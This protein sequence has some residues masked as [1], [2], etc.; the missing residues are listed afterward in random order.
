M[1]TGFK[2]SGFTLIELLVVIAIAIGLSLLTLGF[3]FQKKTASEQRTA[4][5]ED[6]E[7]LFSSTKIQSL[8]G[9]GVL[10]GGQIVVPDEVRVRVR[11]GSVAVVYYSGGT[12]MGTGQTLA[13]PFRNNPEFEIGRLRL[14]NRDD[15]VTELPAAEF[16]VV[17]SRD[18]ISFTGASV[19][20]ASAVSAEM[21]I[22]Y[23]NAYQAVTVDKRANRVQIEDACTSGGCC[24]ERPNYLLDS[25]AWNLPTMAIGSSTDAITGTADI[26]NGVRIATRTFT[27]MPD[28]SFSG[29]VVAEQ[30]A[31]CDAGYIWQSATSSCAP[32]S[33][34]AADGL[35]LDGYSWNV[36]ELQLGSTGMNSTGV[37]SVSHG[38]RSATRTFTC[39]NDG[40]LTGNPLTEGAVTCDAGYTW[41]ATTASCDA[42]KCAAGS[43]Q[44]SGYTWTVPE[45]I[46]GNI[47]A[48]IE[49]A[50]TTITHGTRS[51]TRAFTCI[52][53]TRTPGAV[54]LNP[55]LCES[56]YF[57]STSL[58]ACRSNACEAD[59]T[60]VANG[61]T[62]NA[63]YQDASTVSQTL[64]GT[65]T[66]AGGTRS[67][68]AK[69]SC[70]AT[71]N[72]SLTDFSE[73]AGVCSLG[74]VWSTSSSACVAS[75]C[76]SKP[77]SQSDYVFAFPTTGSGSSAG[78]LTGTK[79]IANGV[80][81]ATASFSCMN[82]TITSGA[83]TVNPTAVCNAGYTWNSV[84]GLCEGA[85]CAANPSYSADGYVWN[86]PL[87]PSG[88]TSAMV[89]GT[90]SVTHGTVYA[91][92]TFSCDAGTFSPNALS[93]NPNGTCDAGY[94]WNLSLRQC[95]GIPCQANSA[96]TASGY[97]FSTPYQAS[98]Y[99]SPVISGRKAVSHGT[100]I[101]RA[102]FSCEQGVR[103]TA[104]WMVDPGVCETGYYWD[105]V[106]V[107][108][109]GVLPP[110]GAGTASGITV[111]N[112]T[113]TSFAVAWQSSTGATSYE[114]STNGGTT[115]TN[116]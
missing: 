38:S 100:S 9:K 111:S 114:V 87:V 103:A 16:D 85:V 2:R 116:V 12:I 23:R 102:S 72:R 19:A 108:C 30:P 71:G 83:M 82:A 51:A 68:T 17:Y 104:T 84:S 6:V 77:Y 37:K 59:T 40:T 106:A 88:Q 62:W 60:L 11:T 20:L 112:I 78:V 75:S 86:A 36:S 56:G 34:T 18:Q 105:G 43:Y 13:Y 50:K 113:G 55:G 91:Y 5:A 96:Y 63:P 44:S 45:Q 47:S 32:Q 74:Y 94:T 110:G 41:N 54:T 64:I 107:T 69:I 52:A 99:S 26:P 95:D 76:F 90:K 79:T 10:I 92:R 115:W 46:S 28:M 22:G 81:T 67:A 27:C 7:N 80:R 73:S 8:V 58:Q 1:R 49:S 61:Y 39:S 14:T 70:D 101:V 93:Q 66:I 33:C 15:S 42:D 21:Q 57:W 48:K 89:T 53:G 24:R 3:D 29:G 4:F 31:V 109:A 65:R 97:S 35:I 98:G 25:Y